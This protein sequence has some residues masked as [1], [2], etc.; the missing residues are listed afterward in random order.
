MFPGG[1]IRQITLKQEAILLCLMDKM[2]TPPFVDTIDCSDEGTEATAPGATTPGATSPGA[3]TPGVS[4]SG[5]TP[6]A[7]PWLDEAGGAN[8]TFPST[9]AFTTTPAAETTPSY[10]LECADA[11]SNKTEGNY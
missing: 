2:T 10:I 7:C 5:Q 4:P 3:T 6:A 8:T 11:E 1:G 9:T